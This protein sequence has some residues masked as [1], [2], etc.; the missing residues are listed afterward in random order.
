LAA[1]RGPITNDDREGWKALA[2]GDPALL[3]MLP[4]EAL[5]ASVKDLAG[6]LLDLTDV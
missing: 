3:A 6:R 4:K 5:I 1:D 2:D